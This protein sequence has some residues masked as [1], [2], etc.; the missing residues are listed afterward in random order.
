LACLFLSDV[1]PDGVAREESKD[2]SISRA[3]KTGRYGSFARRSNKEATMSS[4]KKNRYHIDPSS[5]NAGTIVPCVICN[6]HKKKNKLL[7]LV[8]NSE[9]H[10]NVMMA[11]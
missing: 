3:Q 4:A 1:I 11:V 6:A 9:W 2:K 8:Y 10:M 7:S 5:L